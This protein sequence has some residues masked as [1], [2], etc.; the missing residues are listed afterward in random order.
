MRPTAHLTAHKSWDH[1]SNLCNDSPVTAV[2]CLRVVFDGEAQEYAE[3][4]PHEMIRILLH[5][6]MMLE[7]ALLGVAG[8]ST[9]TWI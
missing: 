9:N 7:A 2:L 8:A 4:E 3:P 1:P 6:M 5:R